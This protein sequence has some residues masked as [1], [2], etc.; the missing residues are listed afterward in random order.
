M[1]I[2]IAT[3]VG[4]VIVEAVAFC[5]YKIIKT[6]KALKEVKENLEGL[7]ECT[8]ELAKRTTGVDVIEEY[9]NRSHDF[10]F[11]DSEGGF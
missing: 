6:E 4:I 11:P 7:S 9:K 1:E 2:V 5:V 10:N 3:I 8:L